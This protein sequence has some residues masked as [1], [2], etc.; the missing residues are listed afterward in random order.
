MRA[1]IYKPAKTAMQSGTRKTRRWR[2]EFIP[3]D[4]LG[5]DP[6]MGWTS[7]PDTTR[8]IRLEFPTREEAVEY[9]ERRGIEYRVEP[10][11]TAREP[12]VAYSDN[13][14]ADRVAPW[15]H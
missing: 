5:V 11:H 7:S 15:T 14:R 9:A 10:E 4:P 13:F 2:L 3:D 6:L 1:R 8:Q 12:K